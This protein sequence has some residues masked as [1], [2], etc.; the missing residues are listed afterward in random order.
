MKKSLFILC[1]VLLLA[2]L[3]A[4]GNSSSAEIVSEGETRT[5]NN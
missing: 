4:C 3:A 5:S 2:L 1:T